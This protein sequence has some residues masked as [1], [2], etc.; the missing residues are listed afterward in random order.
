MAAITGPS[1]GYAGEVNEITGRDYWNRI[2]SSKYGVAGPGDLKVS[3]TT[4]DRMLLV[5]SGVAWGH[6]IMDTLAVSVSIQLDA[7]SS[8]SRWDLVVVRRDATDG[9]SIQVVKGT[10]SKTIPSLTTAGTTHTDQPLALCRVDFGKTTVQ[11]IVDLRVWAANGGATANDDLVR[12]YLN[13]VGTEVEINGIAWQRRVGAN[14]Q[15]EW[16][17]LPGVGEREK[18]DNATW[19]PTGNSL[20]QRH[21]TGSIQVETGVSSKDAANKEYV[22]FHMQDHGHR[23]LYDDA[24]RTRLMLGNNSVSIGKLGEPA[25]TLASESYVEARMPRILSGNT[26][27]T[28]K[29]NTPTS[30]NVKIPYGWFWRTPNIVATADSAV[31]GDAIKGVSVD[32]VTTTGFRLWVHRTNNTPTKVYWIA[33]SD[34]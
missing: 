12:S 3:I 16:V 14:N 9:T 33:H 32:E 27:V 25:R 24:T 15:V 31:I 21:H 30:V 28:P 17:K 23:L 19:Q 11:E 6:N 8:G 7:V 26:T 2:G 13:A 18:L 22:D 5:A 4:G 20:V 10:A 1:L 34:G 29:A